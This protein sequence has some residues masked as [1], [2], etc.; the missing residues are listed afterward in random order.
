MPEQQSAEPARYHLEYFRPIVRAPGVLE[1]CPH[2]SHHGRAFAWCT[3]YQEVRRVDNALRFLTSM[4]L[5]VDIKYFCQ[6]CYNRQVLKNLIKHVHLCGCEVHLMWLAPEYHSP[7]LHGRPD[8]LPHT[9]DQA[10]MPP[11]WRR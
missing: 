7:E 8:W 2:C 5:T 11:Q 3:Q 6:Q 9:I 1:T 4:T 10:V